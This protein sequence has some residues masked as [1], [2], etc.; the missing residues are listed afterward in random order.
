MLS[1]LVA[2][3]E[4]LSLTWTVKVKV[5]AA[6]REPVMAPLEERLRPP[7][8]APFTM[9][10]VYG[11]VPPV[12]ASVCEYAAPGEPPGRLVVV[13]LSEGATVIENGAEA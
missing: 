8:N 4:A 5:P 2:M 6:L 9:D 3:A 1:F 12:A 7:G 11:G 10:Q 13:M